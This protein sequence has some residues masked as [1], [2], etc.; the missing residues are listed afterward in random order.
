M[1]KVIPFANSVATLTAGIYVVCALL[2]YVA[3]DFIFNI[4]QSWVHSLN[5]ETLRS[6]ATLSLGSVVWGLLSITVLA[7]VLGYIFA[8]I[9]NRWAK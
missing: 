3:P 5:I 2:S 4:G 7:W 9:Y 1:F 6:T 8:W